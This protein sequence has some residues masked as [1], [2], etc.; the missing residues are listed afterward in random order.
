MTIEIARRLVNDVWRTGPFDEGGGGALP[1]GGT[2]GQVLTKESNADGDAGWETLSAGVF[3]GGQIGLEV[4]A[5]ITLVPAVRSYWTFD[6]LF[7]DTTDV[8]LDVDNQTLTFNTTGWYLIWY[9]FAA[10]ASATTV[11]SQIQ[12]F[13]SPSDP[14]NWI[15]QTSIGE[16]CVHLDGATSLADLIGVYM[17]PPI[18]FNAGDTLQ[19]AAVVTETVGSV[20]DS[21]VSS[22]TFASVMR[23][24]ENGNGGQ[25]A[26][27]DGEIQYAESGAFAASPG[28]VLDPNGG[29]AILKLGAAPD[30]QVQIIGNA[31]GVQLQIAAADGDGTHLVG[32]ELVLASGAAEV[33]GDVTV[34]AGQGTMDGTGG[35]VSIASG[36]GAGDGG[37]IS[38][39]A[40]GN[41]AVG[42]QGG[43]V[44]VSG[45]QGGSGGA[46]IVQGGAPDGNVQLYSGD[47]NQYVQLDNDGLQVGATKLG[48]FQGAAVSQPVVPLTTPQVQD[49]IDALVALGLVVQHD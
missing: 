24:D 17:A 19:F 16:L 33:G 12:A 2:S 4:S 7:S 15:V 38:I 6:E 23:I 43:Q 44:V 3:A 35:N 18:H 45:G 10:K 5:D 31:P 8:T 30:D 26:G 9:S 32:G 29:A 49:A 40:N 22:N 39:R 20:G 27:N 13:L 25:P 42:G 36:A 14:L 41:S 21:I 34:T 46:A 1:A 11:K 37:E 47:G 48:F 28:F